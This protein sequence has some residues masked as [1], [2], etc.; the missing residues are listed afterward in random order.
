[1]RPLRLE[2]E[3]FTCY[4][5]RQ[6]VLDFSELRLFAIAGPTGAG[7]SSIL[8]TMLYALFGKLP[9]IGKH[10]ISEFISHGRDM[11][12]VTLDFQVRG[13][14]FRV[15][16][17]SKLS[18]SK[19]LKSEATLAE[20]TGGVERSL[21]DQVR[22]VNDAIVEL[23]GLGYD[24]FIQTV[25]LPQ[26]EFAKFLR[27]KP[28]D[29]RAILQHLLRHDVFTRMRDLA[30]DCRR[31]LDAEMRGLEGKLSGLNDATAEALAASKVGLAEARVRQADTAKVR[32]EADL[33]AQDG[34]RR[35]TLTQDAER[36]RS[37]RVALDKEASNVERARGELENARVERTPSCRDWRRPGPQRPRWKRR[38]T[39]MPKS[40]ALRDALQAAKS[41]AADRAAR[42]SE[43]A[44]ECDAL[45][46]RLRSLDEI[47]GDVARR[48]QLGASLK[49]RRAEAMD[50]EKALTVARQAQEL[51]QAKVRGHE[52]RLDELQ[53]ALGEV[54]VDDALL[55]AIEGSFESV[56]RAKALQQEA[57]SLETEVASCETERSLAKRKAADS[58]VARDK[59]QS[60]VDAAEEQLAKA[61]GALEDGRDQDRAATLRAH[62]HAGDACPVCLQTVAGARRKDT[63]GAGR[64]GE[65]TGEGRRASHQSH[66]R[67]SDG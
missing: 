51:S 24:E 21:A 13:R 64:V 10:D 19:Q 20:L 56:G 29:Q 28:S 35:R 23:L 60:V 2:V 57:S 44:R 11:M 18:K 48:A 41:Q 39:P 34:R 32:D 31:E 3:G 54:G 7:K 38:A 9:R 46:G 4:R 59:A 67:Q 30:E 49:S 6:P 1:M 5:D 50:A 15:T 63:A 37:E 27:A 61:R 58:R 47:A 22:P 16:R 14:D 53:A 36:L 52:V 62:L 55:D 8:D 43:A 66:C 26:G 40:A 17:L 12:S 65:S 25:V 42:A 33:E 45:S